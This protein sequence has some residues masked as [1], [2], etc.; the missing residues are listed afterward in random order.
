MEEILASIRQ[1]I[2]EE[3]DEARDGAGAAQE[4]QTQGEDGAAANAAGGATP[5]AAQA[6]AASGAAREQPGRGQGS[7]PGGTA[8]SPGNTAAAAPASGGDAGRPA[9]GSPSGG[10][11]PAGAQAS[12]WGMQRR[13]DAGAAPAVAPL[14]AS[15]APSQPTGPTPRQSLLSSNSDAAISGAFNALAQ[16]VLA[17]NARTLDSM[18]SDALRPLLKDWLDDNLPTLVERLVREEIERVSRGRP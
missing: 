13:S 9:T 10:S 4:T 14:A 16:A 8:P 18:L 3:G 15:P 7:R 6:T 17:Q 5:A 1:I 12:S 11:A 2:S